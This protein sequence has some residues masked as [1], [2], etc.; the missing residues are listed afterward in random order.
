MGICLGYGIVRLTDMNK[1]LKREK[2]RIL[3]RVFAGVLVV[4]GIF[5]LSSEMNIVTD[6]IRGTEAS[7]DCATILKFLCD[8]EETKENAIQL[9]ILFVVD[10]MMAGVMVVGTIGI[11]I[12]GAQIMTARD[13]EEQLRKGKQRLINVMI[14]LVLFIFLGVIIHLLLGGGLGSS[15]EGINEADNV[16]NKLEGS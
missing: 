14:G 8:G 12:A 1:I 5:A 11:I 3:E 10:V 9:L 7:A 4:F 6:V 15:F 16:K 2:K 13:N